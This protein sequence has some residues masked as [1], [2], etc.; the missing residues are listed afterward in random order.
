[1]ASHTARQGTGRRLRFAQPIAAPAEK[2]REKAR[3]WPSRPSRGS[4]PS[5]AIL[6]S[7]VRTWHVPGQN[8]VRSLPKP[9]PTSRVERDIA[10][11]NF[12]GGR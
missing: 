5:Y 1:M 7:G 4:L 2:G 11:Q 8:T 3:A 10:R 12:G 9:L 6:I